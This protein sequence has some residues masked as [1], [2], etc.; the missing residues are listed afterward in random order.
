M[1]VEEL[2]NLMVIFWWFYLGG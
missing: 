1:T 2:T